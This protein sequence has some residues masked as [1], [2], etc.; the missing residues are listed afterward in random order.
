M[1]KKR[2]KPRFHRLEFLL[3]LVTIYLTI[4]GLV[5]TIRLQHEKK[6]VTIKFD[7]LESKYVQQ[8][9]TNDLLRQRLEKSSEEDFIEQRARELDYVYPEEQVFIDTSGNF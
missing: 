4:W 3:L 1:L 9:G 8:L 7:K 5:S 6:Q 2:K